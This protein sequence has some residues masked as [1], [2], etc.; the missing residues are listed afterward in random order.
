VD[1]V[2]DAAPVHA[3][4]PRERVHVRAGQK[5]VSGGVEQVQ[6]RVERVVQAGIDRLG[7]VRRAREEMSH[8]RQRLSELETTLSRLEKATRTPQAENE[9]SAAST[10]VVH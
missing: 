4:D 6:D 8:L 1:R 5:A 7:P 10:T 9:K 2:E 3:E